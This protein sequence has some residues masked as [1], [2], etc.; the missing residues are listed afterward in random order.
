[1]TDITEAIRQL[2][3][4]YPG[5][6]AGEYIAFGTMGQESGMAMYPGGGAA[7][8]SQ[9]KS[10]TGRVRQICRYPLLILSRAGGLAEDA[11]AAAKEQLDGL[12]RWL[13]RLD[14][15]PDLDGDRRLLGFHIERPAYLHTRG[16][17]R[18]ETW[19]VE[20]T[21]RYEYTFEK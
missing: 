19:A 7:I 9:R 6:G 15:Y 10:V 16:E 1:M 8:D 20:I 17:D 4:Q 5:L 18:V 13:E 11:K 14:T 21:A 3:N 12:C 2:V